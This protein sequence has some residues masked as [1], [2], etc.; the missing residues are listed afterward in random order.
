MSGGE[1]H[2]FPAIN[3]REGE[4][5]EYHAVHV[6]PSRVESHKFSCRV[7][8]WRRAMDFHAMYLKG[9]KSH[10]SREIYQSRGDSHE[11]SCHLP[12]RRRRKS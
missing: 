7:P 4:S 6:Y 8:G 10:D 2:D 5:H 9:G 1:N 3:L 12:K 11:F